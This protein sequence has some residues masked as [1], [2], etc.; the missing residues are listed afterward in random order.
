MTRASLLLATLV[1]A[2]SAGALAQGALAQ[3][4]TGIDAGGSERETKTFTELD[5]NSDG[6]LDENELQQANISGSFDDVDSDGD[7]SVNRNEY[8]QYH[9]QQSGQTQ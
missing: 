6:A 1:T 2:L 5:A 4:T 7:G 3:G 8:Y 9:R